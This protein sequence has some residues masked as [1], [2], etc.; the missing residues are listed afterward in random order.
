MIS[1]AAC[2]C[3]HFLALMIPL[4]RLCNYTGNY[5][6][7]QSVMELKQLITLLY[8]YLPNLAFIWKY[9]GKSVKKKQLKV[10][11]FRQQEL[12]QRDG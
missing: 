5:P 1:R 7:H 2:L 8:F 6:S 4:L 10:T 11:A 3:I 12:E 9:G